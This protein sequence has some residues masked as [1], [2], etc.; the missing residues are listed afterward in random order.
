MFPQVGHP[1]VVSGYD[2]VYNHVSQGYL[3]EPS[4]LAKR[5]ALTRIIFATRSL[6]SVGI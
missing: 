2:I 1:L 5:E 3:C 6:T 4:T